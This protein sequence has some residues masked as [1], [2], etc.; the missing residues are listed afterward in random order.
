MSHSTVLVVLPPGEGSINDRISVALAPFDENVEVEPY[1]EMTKEQ[2]IAAERQRH[3]TPC[4]TVRLCAEI[5][6]A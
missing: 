5:R 6:E 3:V 1:V 4:A 2:Q